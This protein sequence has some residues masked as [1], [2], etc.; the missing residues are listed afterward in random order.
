M[1][2]KIIVGLGVFLT[3]SAQCQINA[4]RFLQTI[5][6]TGDT[7]V[8]IEWESQPSAVFSV[9]YSVGLNNDW[10]Q[11]ESGFPAQGTTTRWTDRGNPAAELLVG[12]VDPASVCR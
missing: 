1:Q 12:H 2:R 10:Q 4:P 6:A 8:V 5:K 11:V 3:L 7:P 9:E